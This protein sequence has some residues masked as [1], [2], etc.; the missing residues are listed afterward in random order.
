MKPRSLNGACQLNVQGRPQPSASTE[1]QD[2]DSGAMKERIAAITTKI[3]DLSEEVRGCIAFQ[4]LN[5]ARITVAMCRLIFLTALLHPD[6]MWPS[7]RITDVLW[8]LLCDKQST[9]S[10]SQR[11]CAF[12]P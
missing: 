3:E 5:A 6:M 9:K 7:W 1:E 12:T 11:G 2:D 4:G 8:R 10:G